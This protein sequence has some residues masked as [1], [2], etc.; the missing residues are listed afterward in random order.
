MI[1]A[2][3]AKSPVDAVIA[4]DVSNR[5]IANE[6]DDTDVLSDDNEVNDVELADENEVDN[7]SIDFDNGGSDDVLLADANDILREGDYVLVVQG[8]FR[9]LYAVVVRKSYGDEF[10]IQYFREK[11]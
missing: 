3:G 8:L 4:T 7:E 5:D 2:A 9:G 1:A 11:L 10:K 6:L